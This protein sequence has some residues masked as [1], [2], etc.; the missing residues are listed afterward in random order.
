MVPGDRINSVPEKLPTKCLCI[1]F[2]Y[3][4]YCKE[5]YSLSPTTHCTVQK[6]ILFFHK[7]FKL[8]ILSFRWENQNWKLWM[9]KK[10]QKKTLTCP[11]WKMVWD[12]S[13]WKMWNLYVVFI[14]KVK[15]ELT[16][17]E[18][19][20]GGTKMNEDEKIC[21]LEYSKTFSP[22]LLLQNFLLFQNFSPNWPHSGS[23]H[24]QILRA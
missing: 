20:F 8:F 13:H 5:D 4:H 9:K 2:V 6:K 19:V 18:L 16:E 23:V 15:A 17:S 1:L 14:R 11:S 3:S 7:K 10:K 24:L 12:E 22:K 21:I